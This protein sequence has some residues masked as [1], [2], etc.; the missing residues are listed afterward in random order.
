M[1]RYHRWYCSSPRWAKCLEEAVLPWA[2]RDIELGADALEIGPGPG[3]TTR[4]LKERT[5]HLTAIE[6]DERLAAALP[7]RLGAS[8]VT[9]VHGDATAM[10][11]EGGRFSGAVCLTMLHHVP[12]AE[13]QDRLLVE[14]F[15]VLEPGAM[16]AGSDSVSS[17]RFR[18]AHLFDTMVLVDPGTFAGRLERAGFVEARVSARAGGFRFSARKPG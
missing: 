10:P 7:G 15:R 9:V 14:A 6:V 13:L 12:S 16:F 5:A 1:N 4:L 2:L 11:F 3:L 18:L 17:F 8:N